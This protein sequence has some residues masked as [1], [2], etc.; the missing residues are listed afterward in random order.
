[1]PG[2]FT[3]VYS[4][5]H[6]QDMG[7]RGL[8]CTGVKEFCVYPTTELGTVRARWQ[9]DFRG[10]GPLSRC[11]TGARNTHTHTENTEREDARDGHPL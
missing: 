6:Q 7:G 10:A 8:L 9:H 11:A 3:R 4:F 2:H 1:M 5:T